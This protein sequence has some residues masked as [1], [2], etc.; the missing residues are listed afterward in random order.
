MGNSKYSDPLTLKYHNKYDYFTAPIVCTPI[1]VDSN[2][3][4]SFTIAIAQKVCY[5]YRSII[6][7]IK[8]EYKVSDAAPTIKLLGNSMLMYNRDDDS[9]GLYPLLEGASVSGVVLK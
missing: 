1:S 4:I 7:Y 2:K 8:C 3:T 5:G 6:H 9:I